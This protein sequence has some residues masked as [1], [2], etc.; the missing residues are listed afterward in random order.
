[1]YAGERLVKKG[2]YRE[3]EPLLKEADELAP[4]SDKASLLLAK[5]ACTSATFAPRKRP[6]EDT[7]AV[8]TRPATNS[9]KCPVCGIERPKR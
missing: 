7:K 2:N 1:M 9:R 6:S 5:A 3:A 4:Q 8:T